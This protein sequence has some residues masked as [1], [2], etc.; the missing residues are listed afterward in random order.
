MQP[1]LK[2]VNTFVYLFQYLYSYNLFLHILDTPRGDNEDLHSPLVSCESCDKSFKLLLVHLGKVQKCKNFYGPARLDLI[3]LD[4][5]KKKKDLMK[6]VKKKVNSKYYEKN[7]EKILGARKRKNME[8]M[9]NS[10]SNRAKFD[11]AMQFGPEFV[12]VCCHN[13]RFE[14]EV[15]EFVDK[16]QT[17]IKPKIIEASC[18]FEGAFDDPRKKGVSY[19]CKNCYTVMAKKKTMPTQSVKNGL[20]LDEIPDNLADLNSFEKQMIALKLLFLKIKKLPKSRMEAQVDRTILVPV[21]PGDVMNNIETLPRTKENNA[22]YADWKRMKDMKNTHKSGYARPLKMYRA[23]IELKEAGHQGYQN[24]I[25]QCLICKKKFTDDDNLVEHT[26]ECCQENGNEDMTENEVNNEAKD[27]HQESVEEENNAH[28]KEDINNK[29]DEDQE[30]FDESDALSSVKKYQ[31]LCESSCIQMN[32]PEVNVVINT[33]D[34][35]KECNVKDSITN[36]KVVLAPGEGKIPTNIM[37]ESEFDVYAFPW[38]HPT[39][40]YGLDFKRKKKISKQQY[41]KNRHVQ[42]LQSF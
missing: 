34:K 1:P 29:V 15:H 14:N 8:A 42:T 12:C 11:R 36:E 21:E 37:R 31:T 30:D 18:I 2:F 28:L 4:L 10:D 39:G 41:F 38:L 3:R 26:E 7:R 17:N 20:F 32:Y 19:V 35:P 23:I 6:K 27:A 40:W 9:K 16:R 24:V 22:I 13:G 33:S 25:T 5:M